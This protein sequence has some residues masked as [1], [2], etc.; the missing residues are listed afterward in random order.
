MTTPLHLRADD[1]QPRNRLIAF[2]TALVVL[3]LLLLKPLFDSYF[4]SMYSSE[5]S[6]KVLTQPA[7][8]L[9]AIRERERVLLEE[10]GVPLDRVF[11]Q[12]AR[13]RQASPA[14]IAPQPS[15]AVDAIKGWQGLPA[16]VHTADR[17]AVDPAAAAAAAAAAAP[18]PVVVDPAAAPADP[19]AAPAAPSAVSADPPG[20]AP[21]AVAPVAAAPAAPAAAPH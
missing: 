6:V 12:L 20:G 13:G 3:V 9:E 14:I 5:T 10:R 17:N 2:Y 1:T 21:A 18:A 16:F 4:E 15:T 11:S 19:A 8:E 7:V